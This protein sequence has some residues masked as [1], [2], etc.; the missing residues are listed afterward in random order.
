[1]RE[2]PVPQDLEVP[3][4]TFLTNHAHVLL[5]VA[6]VPDIRLRH[7]ALRVGIS[8]RAV[9]EIV[10][11]LDLDGY[12]VVERVGRRNHYRV[13]PDLPLRHPL[14]QRHRIGDLLATLTDPPAAPPS[15]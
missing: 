9:H 13:N 14:E 10:K 2:Q 5:C 6:E 3:R 11:D 12:L 4:W 8:E 1:M 15:I 7:I